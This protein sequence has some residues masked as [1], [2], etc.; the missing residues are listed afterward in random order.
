V[1]EEQLPVAIPLL[2]ARNNDKNPRNNVEMIT[3]HVGGNDVKGPIQLACLGGF[4]Y[5]CLSTFFTVMATYEADLR[6]VVAEL[7]AAAGA[8]TPI[9]LGTYDNPIPFCFLGMIPGAIPLGAIV[10]E[11]T[12][13]GFLD[14]V[15]DIVRRVAADFGAEVAEAFRPLGPDDFVGGNDCLHVT[16]SG[17]DKVTAA[18]LDAL[19]F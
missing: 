8:D 12:P 3:L 11:G 7:R 14:G 18:F 2:E 9:V 5:E 13:D 6:G 10:L 16:D 1:A 17:H 15:H 4:T 19:G